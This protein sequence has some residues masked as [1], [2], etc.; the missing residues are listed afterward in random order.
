MRLPQM[1]TGTADTSASLCRRSVRMRP[2]RV[3]SHARPRPER[4]VAHASAARSLILRP[5][6]SSLTF[7]KMEKLASLVL[8]GYSASA[9]VAIVVAPWT[10][11]LPGIPIF[12]IGGAVAVLTIAT[13][14]HVWTRLTRRRHDRQ[15]TRSGS[16]SGMLQ[17]TSGGASRQRGP[18]HAY[19]NGGKSP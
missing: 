11:L 9:F 10:G 19:V 3:A 15:R 12:W 13:F 14:R 6:C 4:R 2:S 17:V 16:A 5:G 8:L 1:T 7:A 18:G